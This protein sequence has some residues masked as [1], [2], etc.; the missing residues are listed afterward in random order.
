MEK[1]L[2]RSQRL[3]DILENPHLLV[4]YASKKCK[5]YGRGY[6]MMDTRHKDATEWTQSKVVCHCVKKAVDKERKELEQEDG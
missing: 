4:F 3:N 1:K 5:C 2:T 6:L